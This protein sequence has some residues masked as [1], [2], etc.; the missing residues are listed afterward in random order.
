MTQTDLPPGLEPWFAE[1]LARL[2]RG[3]ISTL[4][5]LLNSHEQPLILAG[6][7]TK[8]RTHF[9]AFDANG[10]PAVD[11]FAAAVAS[12]ITDFCVP[13]ARLMKAM[14]VWQT[15]GSTSAITSLQHQARAL[16][17]DSEKSGE[18]GELLLFMLLEQILGIPQLISKMALKTSASMH[19]HGTDGIHASLS[20]EGILDL[21]WGES[22]LHKSTSSAFSE[23][24]ES[25]APY[26]AEDGAESRQRD[27]LLVRQNLD[28]G[29]RELTAHLIK[30]FDEA[31]PEALQVRFRGACLVGFDHANYPNLKL[32][33]EIQGKALETA[34]Q[35]WHSS[36][37]NHVGTHKLHE[38]NIDLFC[39]PFP[40]VQ[41]LRKSINASIG[42][43]K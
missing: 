3:D 33:T 35:R 15:T 9:L 11:L 34:V 26:L 10:N 1:S 27:L 13:R 19:V 20:S 2:V 39:I 41:Q 24:F 29:Q 8:V 31:E 42:V 6:T 25:L 23:C 32:L 18:G 5:H 14:E 7:L 21:Y 36:I 40:S 30:F 37:E 12:S 4:G 22:K 16:F 17:V 28:L 38:V 43:T